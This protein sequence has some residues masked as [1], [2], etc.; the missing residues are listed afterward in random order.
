M[1]NQNILI[2]RFFNQIKQLQWHQKMVKKEDPDYI[3]EDESEYDES[4]EFSDEESSINK[5][6]EKSMIKLKKQL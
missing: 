3:I 1:K 6:Y 2:R 5:T 4:E